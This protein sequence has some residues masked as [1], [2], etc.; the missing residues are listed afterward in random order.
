MIRF[1]DT[2]DFIAFDS[3]SEGLIKH[4]M[5]NKLKSGKELGQHLYLKEYY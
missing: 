1:L 2:S 5:Q 3:D 4:A